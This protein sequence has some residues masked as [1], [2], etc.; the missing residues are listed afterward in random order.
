MNYNTRGKLI[1]RFYAILPDGLGVVFYVCLYIDRDPGILVN[2]DTSLFYPWY[3]SCSFFITRGLI[4]IGTIPKKG[5][6][7]M[8]LRYVWQYNLSR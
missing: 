2:A 1:S 8:W 3:I 7:I 6:Y 4:S 5:K